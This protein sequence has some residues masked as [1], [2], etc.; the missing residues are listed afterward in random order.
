MTELVKDIFGELCVVIDRCPRCHAP[1]YRRHGETGWTLLHRA[2][3][4]NNPGAWR[5]EARFAMAES[6]ERDIRQIEQR[7]AS[8]GAN[9]NAPSDYKEAPRAPSKTGVT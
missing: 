6:G 5:Q 4:H 3:C 7:I 8:Y 2:G 1:R 9:V